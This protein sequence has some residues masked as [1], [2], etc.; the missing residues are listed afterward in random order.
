MSKFTYGDGGRLGIYSPSDRSI[1]SRR[2]I[3]LHN[4]AQVKREF[5]RSGEFH[6][7]DYTNL[8][9]LARPIQIQEQ[10]N[11]NFETVP[12]LV[13]NGHCLCDSGLHN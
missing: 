1:T 6:E 7:L 13:G 2:V 8:I 5:V 12:L 10:T 11:S 9:A 4:P 3:R